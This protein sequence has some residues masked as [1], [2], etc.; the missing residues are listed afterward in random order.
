MKSAPGNTSRPCRAWL[1]AIAVLL[2]AA[3][4]AGAGQIAGG[5]Q[6]AAKKLG[7]SDKDLKQM[8]ADQRE[9]DA[10]AGVPSRMI[11]LPEGG[12]ELAGPDSDLEIGE[13]MT[14]RDLLKD[15]ARI[16][17]LLR[18]EAEFRYDPQ[19]RPDPMVAPW[20][21][22]RVM[23][24]E[25]SD[26]AENAMKANDLARARQAYTM[27]QALGDRLRQAGFQIGSIQNFLQKAVTGLSKVS[28]LEDEQREAQAAAS[29]QGPPKAKLPRWVKN[30]TRGIIYDTVDPICLV[31]P[32]TLRQG[33]TVPGQSVEVIVE[34]I[35]PAS[36]VYR[37]RDTTFEVGVEEGE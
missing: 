16:R 4:W 20:I 10:A 21:R 7:P 33:D 25:L 31:G 3:P 17:R 24:E 29:G 22:A 15:D 9:A 19:G 32:H 2:V 18:E 27:V 8:Q 6:G 12:R 11:E 35:N 28:G 34:K 13:T 37:V 5:I 23:A 30:N 36:V 26:I 14:P 1:F